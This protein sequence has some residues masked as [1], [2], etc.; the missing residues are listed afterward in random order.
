VTSEHLG[1]LISAHLDGE[2][3]V[4]ESVAFDEHLATCAECR[5]ELEAT[6]VVRN[7]L[8]GA[9]AVDPPFGFYER[10]FLRK[11]RPR[12]MAVASAI[13]TAAL[14][15]GIVGFATTQPHERVRPPVEAARASVESSQR[16]SVTVMEGN[17][18]WSSLTGGKRDAVANL[19]GTPWESLDSG[20]PN[21]L[22]FED[23][24]TSVLVVGDVPTDQLEAF[25]RTID[26]SKSMVDRLRDAANAVVASFNWK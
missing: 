22:V 10:M 18:E 8:R 11:R 26:T 20:E 23:D 3:T 7:A 24:G 13:G 21:A 25:A 12:A 1:E 19:P 17:V 15:A 5:A 6:R 4:E 9:P 2:L 14:W 16:I